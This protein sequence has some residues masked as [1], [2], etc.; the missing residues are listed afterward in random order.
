MQDT[1]DLFL[2]QASLADQQYGMH[3]RG[4]N[5]YESFE[6]G[7]IGTDP[8]KTFVAIIRN[9]ALT[10]DQRQCRSGLR[11]SDLRIDCLVL[12]FRCFSLV[13]QSKSNQAR[14]GQ[15]FSTDEHGY[16]RDGPELMLDPC[17]SVFIR[18]R[19]DCPILCCSDL[20]VSILN[21]SASLK[22]DIAPFKCLQHRVKSSK[23]CKSLV[24]NS[25]R[26]EFGDAGSFI[27][28]HR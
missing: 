16:T 7:S 23:T 14:S 26:L 22:F 19:N 8:D 9:S 15:K 3:L 28:I 21:D 17:L 5:P 13:R 20:D 18:G 10:I 1:R 6:V 4:L 11:L 27:L 12:H 2:S 25:C 24:K